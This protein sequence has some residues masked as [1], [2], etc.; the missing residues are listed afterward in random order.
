MPNSRKV[1]FLFIL[2]LVL[3]EAHAGGRYQNPPDNLDQV[4]ASAAKAQD[5]L[6]QGQR[7][8]ALAAAQEALKL[9]KESNEIKTTAPMQRATGQLRMI[10]GKLKRGETSQAADQLGA[11]IRYLDEVAKSYQ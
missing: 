3:V 7:A 6:S 4:I 8:E 1:W 2:S 5:L 9:A 10:V 11:I